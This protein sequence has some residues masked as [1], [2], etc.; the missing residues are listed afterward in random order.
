MFKY[1]VNQT[2]Y[3]DCHHR[4]Y[5]HNNVVLNCSCHKDLAIQPSS[6]WKCVFI[7]DG[8]REEGFMTM[9]EAESKFMS[10]ANWEV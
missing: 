2:M 8:N 1:L 6:T 9:E 10:H 5:A 4:V 3:E 7:V